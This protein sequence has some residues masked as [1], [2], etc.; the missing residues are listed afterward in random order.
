[1]LTKTKAAATSAFGSHTQDEFMAKLH[2]FFTGVQKL[3]DDY[4]AKH[5]P[6]VK[7]GAWELQ[8]L[9]KRVRVVHDGSAW[10]FVDMASGDVLKPHGWDRPAK[11][12][13]GNIYDDKNGLGGMGPYGPATLR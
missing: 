6:S 1:M 12:A 9:Q 7:L 10:V 5:F 11:H 13:R 8:W 3:H 2:T 4:S